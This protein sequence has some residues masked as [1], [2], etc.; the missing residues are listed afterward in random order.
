MID[1]I[2]ILIASELAKEALQCVNIKTLSYD[3]NKSPAEMIAA[4]QEANND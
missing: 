4:D 2:D 1:G 3:E